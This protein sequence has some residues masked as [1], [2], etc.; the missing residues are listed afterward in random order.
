M[1]RHLFV[2]LLLIGISLSAVNLPGYA[3][4]APPLAFA[5]NTPRPQ[6][7]PVTTPAAPIDRYALRI[8]RPE[9]LVE[10]L[11]HHVRQLSPGTTEI[12]KIVRLLQFELA[13]RFP[14]VDVSE[15]DEAFQAMLD[16]PPGSMDMRD[17]VWSYVE[18]LMNDRS[19]QVM[20]PEQIAFQIDIL[21]AN[22]DGR[23]A[24]DAVLHVRYPDTD[25]PTVFESYIPA[26]IDEAG[27][28]R[29]LPAPDLPAAPA[30]DVESVVLVGIG[31]FN[32][33]GLDELAL[34]LD[35]GGI[36]DE[37][38]IYEARS[39]I[40][41]GIV[42]P[43][44][45][46]YFGELVDG[47]QGS[48]DIT[49]LLYRIESAAWNCL[50]EQEVT[51]R[52]NANFYRPA[53][54][55]EGFF[56]QN[57]PNCLFYGAEPLFAVPPAEALTTINEVMTFVPDEADPAG[58]RA[59]LI[60]AMI[61]ALDG[62]FGTALAQVLDL[63]TRA[64]PGS[65]LAQQT[66]A[67]IT[68]L[69]DQ[70]VTPLQVCAALVEASPHG[71]CNVDDAL[72]QLLERQPLRRDLPVDEQLAALGIDVL[73]QTT[74]AQVGR[75]DREV[76]RFNLAGNRWWAFAPLDREFYTAERFE[77]QPGFEP[78]APPVPV[79]VASPRMLDALLVE[80]D[81]ALVLNILENMQR[82]NPQAAISPEIRYLQ[83][84]SYDL[85]ADRSRARQAYYSLWQENP[86]SI[87]AQL[88]ADHLEQR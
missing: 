73:D 9:A 57:T 29:L 83:A 55:S 25:A 28:Y 68:A 76:V 49:V 87:W 24:R 40:L 31:D 67:F 18:R 53:P 1:R 84:L 43:G 11:H 22:I 12:Q 15:Y 62:D 64:E 71:A 13:W 66:A 21:P 65:W 69:S 6:P 81:P 30:V 52:W 47:L 50:G 8:W 7:T 35:V 48:G 4:D 59:Q 75:V 80:R 70:N 20:M 58:Q 72:E 38:R 27:N 60:A 17:V 86:L 32:G 56:F 3:Q 74:V 63:E 51:W 45:P 19:G 78:V 82:E 10:A 39:G 54:A 77:P 26:V 61:R 36:N 46:L 85:L 34:S 14:R 42:Q 37:L 5:T 41:T 23:G 16:A 33:N 44:V 79:L 88:A 2:L